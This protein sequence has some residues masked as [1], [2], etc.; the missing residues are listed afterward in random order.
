M[1]RRGLVRAE[2]AVDAD[3]TAVG[4]LRADV[5]GIHRPS[6]SQRLRKAAATFLRRP[7]E[8]RCSGGPPPTIDEFAKQ[9]LHD[10]LR[11]A[12]ATMVSKLDGLGEYE[13]RRPL[14]RTGTNLL[15]LVKHLTVTE[16]WYFG[17]VFER[18]FT[19][20]LP[21]R[22]DAG[23]AS[24][25]GG[26]DTELTA[27]FGHK[28]QLADMWATE[29]ESQA[30]IIDRYQ[31]I[32][33]HADA[34]IDALAIDAPGFV[35]RWPRPHVMLFNILVHVLTETMRHAGHADILRGQLDGT[36]GPEATVFGRDATFWR[37]HCADIERAARA[38]ADGSSSRS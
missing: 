31:R 28:V 38:A 36:V 29:H 37:D 5:D 27:L 2:R 11:D 33:G 10:D 8:H 22:D 30:D 19:G 20:P 4:E 3:H 17:E 34:T 14:T 24:G 32:C 35:A 21:W 26:D 16:A 25:A 7:C 12:R 23:G 18:P 15:G 9:Y 1:H 13:I 6:V